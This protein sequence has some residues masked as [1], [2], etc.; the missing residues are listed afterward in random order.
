MKSWGFRCLILDNFSSLVRVMLMLK[1]M[2]PSDCSW[3]FLNCLR[4]QTAILRFHAVCF[5]SM[6]PCCE[7]WG[8]P[9][10]SLKIEGDETDE[11]A[12]RQIL[13]KLHYLTGYT[14]PLLWVW[15]HFRLANSSTRINSQYPSKGLTSKHTCLTDIINVTPAG[16]W[17]K[18]V[19]RL[20]WPGEE[21][22]SLKQWVC[23]L[24]A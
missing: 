7:P 9:W 8:L 10:G 6:L 13:N 18:E 15:S 3:P 11:T 16:L 5:L 14:Q 22:T 24:L 1:L 12:A 23:A 20:R 4:R 17:C 2:L 21:I 19:G